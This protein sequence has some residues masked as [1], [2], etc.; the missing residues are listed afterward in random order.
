MTEQEVREARLAPLHDIYSQASADRNAETAAGC[1]QDTQ[2]AHHGMQRH[3]GHE[4]AGRA[5]MG[6]SGRK[7]SAVPVL[8]DGSQ[9]SIS[10][11]RIAHYY[12]YLPVLHFTTP[13]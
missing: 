5:G 13:F 2:V 11:D 8:R 4:P 3:D 6:G 1:H 9:P 10:I 12:V 7:G